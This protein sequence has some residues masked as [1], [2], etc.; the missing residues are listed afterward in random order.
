M[1]LFEKQQRKLKRSARLIRVLSKYGFQDLLVRLH[2]HPYQFKQGETPITQLSAYERVRL[3]LEELGPTFVKLGQSFSEREDLLPLA[4]I[5][6]LRLLQDRVQTSAIDVEQELKTAFGE[7]VINVFHSINPE[8]IAAASIAQVY[9]GVLITGEKVIIKIKRKGIDAVIADDILILKDLLALVDTYSDVVEQ[10]NLKSALNAFER[11]LLEELSLTNERNNIARFAEQFTNHEEIYVPKVFDGLCNDTIL[12]MEFIEGTKITDVLGLKAHDLDAV[13]LSEKG[14][15]VYVEQILDHGFFHA[16]PH[17][18]NIIVNHVGQIV[19]IDFGAM[20]S[21]PEVDRPLFENLILAFM[22]K[23]AN[24]IV[25]LLKKMALYYKIPDERKFEM[26]VMDILTY[27]HS[28]VLKDISVA[29]VI[30]MMKGVL[31][32][33]RLVMPEY[34]YLLFKGI[35]LMDGVGRQLNPE[36]DVVSSLKPYTKKIFLRRLN[37]DYIAKLGT[38]KATEFMDNMEEIPKE[39]RSLL[40]KLEENKF[41]IQTEIR[42]FDRIE[43]LI[44]SSVVNI[45]LS[46]VLAANIIATAFLIRSNASEW[47]ILSII[48]SLLLIVIL[49]LRLLR[50]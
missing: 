45:I 7:S 29:E 6:Q 39:M 37:P 42:Q 31:K 47:I 1:G 24:K 15:R 5:E 2:I 26:D 19:F 17:A 13:A 48:F 25:R 18:G 20:G 32:D 3:A 23:Q 30:Q 9:E 49:V 27:V 40:Y 12:T 46:I 14:Y 35:S 11:S 22:A 41:S 44:K 28:S 21:I 10:V 16:D 43:M 34:F 8:P 4:L 38:R 50:R 36:L 33:N